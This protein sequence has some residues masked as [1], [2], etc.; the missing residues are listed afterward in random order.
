M[1]N[2]YYVYSA[3]VDGEVIYIGSGKDGRYTHVTSGK[4]H[5]EG[6]NYLYRKGETINV[7]IVAEGLSKADARAYE[8]TLIDEHRPP[9]NKGVA[10]SKTSIKESAE[11]KDIREI[12]AKASPSIK[13]RNLCN[14]LFCA[15][16]LTDQPCYLVVAFELSI[17]QEDG[18]ITYMREDIDSFMLPY[19]K[20][21]SSDY[22][23]HS[24]KLQGDQV[25]ESTYEDVMEHEF[26]QDVVN[27]D[28]IKSYSVALEKTVAMF[29][30][31]NLSANQSQLFTTT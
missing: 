3:S 22:R 15:Y 19:S 12:V 6:L 5:N 28:L 16:K 20:V 13:I 10:A 1:K 11:V 9:F 21:S 31:Y 23:Q 7:E 17:M 8:Q 26:V 2:E 29:E 30:T 27:G 25:Y 24:R 14:L 18:S 4:S